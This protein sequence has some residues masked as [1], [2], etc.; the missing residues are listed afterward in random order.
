[1]F[2]ATKVQTLLLSVF[3]LVIICAGIGLVARARRNDYAETARTGF[4]V[5]IGIVVASLGLGTIA[6]A[7][8]GKK[9]L[10]SFGVV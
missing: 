7:A 1:M 5:I 3:G 8:F 9:L 10:Q 6:V 2:D 4:N